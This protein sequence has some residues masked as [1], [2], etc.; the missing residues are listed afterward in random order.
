MTVCLQLRVLCKEATVREVGDRSEK[1]WNARVRRE[2]SPLGSKPL[3][4][5]DMC[6]LVFWKNSSCGGEEEREG[7]KAERVG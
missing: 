4:K 1:A 6:L 2:G 5:G 7:G 3:S